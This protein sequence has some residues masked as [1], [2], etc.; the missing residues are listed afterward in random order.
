MP[1]QDE[2]T[3]LARWLLPGG[4]EPDPRFTLANERTFLAWIRTGLGLIAGGIAIEGFLT[5]TLS[6]PVRTGFV[7]GLL[8]L[9]MVVSIGAGLRWVRVERAMRTHSPLPFPVLVP[10]LAVGGVLA[11]A[12]VLIVV[13]TLWR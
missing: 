11:A 7:V 2:R 9:G 8:V 12:V 5:Q 3:R 1:A 13:I 4:T 6:T 10:L